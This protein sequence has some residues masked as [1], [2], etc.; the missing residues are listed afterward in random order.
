[1]VGGHLLEGHVRPTLE[2]ILT[3]SPGHLERQFDEQSGTA[4]IRL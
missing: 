1:M 4:L 2:V 3:Q